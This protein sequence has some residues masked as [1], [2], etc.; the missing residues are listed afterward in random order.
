MVEDD[1]S[2]VMILCFGL[3]AHQDLAHRGLIA[4]LEIH[5]QL[6]NLELYVKIGITSGRVFC[7]TIG[8]ANRYEYVL[9]GDTVNTAARLMCKVEELIGRKGG[10]ILDNETHK[11][12]LSIADS[13]VSVNLRN[14]VLTF[15]QLPSVKLKGKANKAV[16]YTP[17][18][19]GAGSRLMKQPF[20]AQLKLVMSGNTANKENAAEVIEY[21]VKRTNRSRSALRLE[22]NYLLVLGDS[23]TG[24]SLFVCQLYRMFLQQGVIPLVAKASKTKSKDNFGA[25]GSIL[26]V[27]LT[28]MPVP[29]ANDTWVPPKYL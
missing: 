11:Q 22:T 10:I 29:A 13:H 18:L 28:C 16:I 9:V 25:L 6:A 2:T 14:R 4:A 15:T 24:K 19:V 5:N 17:H 1:K 23:N 20:K 26:A 7:G 3:I 8:S 12:V 27:L 21:A